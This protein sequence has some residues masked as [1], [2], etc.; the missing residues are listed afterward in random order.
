MG[1][2]FTDTGAMARP[3]RFG[4]VSL[5]LRSTLWCGC[6]QLSGVPPARRLPD[7]RRPGQRA[8]GGTVGEGHR[9][10]ACMPWCNCA[11]QGRAQPGHALLDPASLPHAAGY[12]EH[13][14]VKTAFGKFQVAYDAVG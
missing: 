13:G 14:Q 5:C 12:D 2:E 4:L 1:R 3:F 9:C 11:H 8:H 7:A 10:V 6:D